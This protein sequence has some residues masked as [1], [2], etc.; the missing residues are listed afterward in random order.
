MID[1]ALGWGQVAAALAAFL[2]SHS[3]PAR[4]RTRAWL[5]GHLGSR[6][7]IACYSAVSLLVLAWL[8]TATANAPYL[9]LWPRE[10]WQTIIPF[11]AMPV[12]CLLIVDGVTRANPLSFGGR[13]KLEYDPERPGIAGLRHP[14]L[15]AALLWSSSHL[16]PN[17]DLAHVL[18]FGLFA[19]LAAGGMV[20]FDRRRRRL[21]GAQD[22]AA[23]A[24]NTSNIPFAA[25]RG[26]ATVNWVA[27][28][29]RIGAAAALYGLLV[30]GHGLFAGIA[31]IPA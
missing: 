13:R 2:L 16:V 29:A 22:W 3:L 14:I 31:L 17:G 1:E 27:L 7:Y 28:L 11:L 19:G 18:M 4:P 9:E 5:V 30:A 21:L 6:L 26:G 10:D 15:W 23:L 25:P 20:M 12:A 24:R 8:I